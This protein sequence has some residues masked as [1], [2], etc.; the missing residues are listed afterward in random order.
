MAIVIE[1]E[2]KSSVSILGILTW[3]II[4][5][6]IVLSGYYLFFQ[7]PDIIPVAVPDNFKNTEA[8]SNVDPNLSNVLNDPAFANLKNPVTSPTAPATGRPNPFLGF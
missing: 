4:L 8:L 7:R 3:V 2:R 6:A 5:G 1:E